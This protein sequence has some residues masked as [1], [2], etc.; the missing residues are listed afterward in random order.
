MM[1]LRVI[2]LLLLLFPGAALSNHAEFTPTLRKAWKEMFVL[3]FDS[4]YALTSQARNQAAAAYIESYGDFLKAFI[5]EEEK[6]FNRLKNRIDERLDQVE[7][8][9]SKSPW[10]RMMR[11]EM[12]LHLAVVKFKWKEYFTAAYYFRKSF[13]LLEDNKR[14]FPDFAPNQRA[15]GFFH[16]AIG[17][18]PENY[19]W[20]SNLIGL[21]GTV[22]QGE[23]ELTRVSQMIRNSKEWGFMYDETVFLKALMQGLFKKD[24]ESAQATLSDPGFGTGGQGAMHTF[25]LANSFAAG[26]KQ[27]QALEILQNFNAEKG[28]YP[29]LYLQF[30]R[31]N[32]MLNRLDL[33]AE[34]YLLKYTA[35]FK[36]R[37][38][39]RSAWH[40]L[41]WI[42]LLKGNENG[43]QEKMKKITVT[44]SDFTDE[45]KQAMKEA[46]NG[47]KPDL[48]LL[49]SRLL[50]DGG[51]YDRA[52][53]EI[54]RKPANYWQ[55]E[56]DQ[57]EVTYRLA[58]IHDQQNQFDQAISL[59]QKTYNLWKSKEWYFASNA[60]LH[61]AMIYEKQ[62]L[63]AKAR[64]WYRKTLALRNHEYQ[65]SIDQKAEA[66]LDRVGRR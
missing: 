23:S 55:R 47:E 57:A 13:H 42:E 27:A 50:F 54:S 18:V 49:R 16:A 38:F 35:E 29:M 21:K 58:R 2:I 30:M 53:E 59:Y 48:T 31:G 56:R 20:I 33:T 7:K 60:A 66:G 17:T 43:Y 9:S 65:D 19:K 41:A 1:N 5:S 46:V 36:G 44:G 45:D 40:K 51:L 14:A 61:L 8:I 3:Q 12:L 52:L 28:S 4:M 6:D 39:I 32:F 24:Y 34:K 11:A 26:G 64:E 25:I 22:T 63:P 10:K 15:L 62:G 37:S